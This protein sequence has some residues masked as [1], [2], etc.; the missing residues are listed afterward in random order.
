MVVACLRV[1]LNDHLRGIFTLLNPEMAIGRSRTNAMVLLGLDVARRH[2]VIRR[3]ARRHVL[4]DTSTQGVRVNAKVFDASITLCHDDLIQVGPYCLAYES[5]P[6]EG[7]W[8]LPQGP[9]PLPPQNA[10][11]FVLSV[12]RGEN[13]GM[14]YRLDQALT[15]IGRGERNDIV[16]NDL[17]VSSFHAELDVQPE[18]VYLRDLGSTNGTWVDGEKCLCVALAAGAKVQIGKTLLTLRCRGE[19]VS[20]PAIA[21]RSAATT[22]WFAEI[23]AA[24]AG[25]VPLLIRAE[26]G[27]ETPQVAQEIHRLGCNAHQPFIPIDCREWPG[28]AVLGELFG[29]APPEE[30]DVPQSTVGVFERVRKGTLFL[31]AVDALPDTVR[32][33]IFQAVSERA[34]YPAGAHATAPMSC[35]AILSACRDDF[36]PPS[37]FD[38]RPI[39][40]PPLRERKDEIPARVG[41][42]GRSVTSG[43]LDALLAHT[44]P[45]NVFELQNTLERA[46]LLA[47]GDT[48]RKEDLIFL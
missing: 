19:S 10:G 39:R 41:H 22:G 32:D 44:W 18:G 13:Q 43:A 31:E 12:A 6:S 34:F 46:A 9:A 37:G 40:I 11:V 45:G 17:A 14:E 1:Y 21:R 29:Q 35:R 24:S 30:G 4:T 26:A 25:A 28:E 20:I 8:M 16:L 33:R 23:E 15:R 42:F 48:L 38:Y 2:A 47:E 5:A 36:S 27:C 3:E 7:A